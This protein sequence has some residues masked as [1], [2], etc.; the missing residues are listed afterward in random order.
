MENWC[1]H[2]VYTM[3]LPLPDMGIVVVPSAK[4]TNFVL[5]VQSLNVVNSTFV[6][7]SVCEAPESTNILILVLSMFVSVLNTL[8]VISLEEYLRR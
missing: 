1:P 7:I 4:V 8:T 6:L 2:F 5:S 3:I